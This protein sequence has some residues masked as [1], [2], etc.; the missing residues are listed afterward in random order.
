[1]R[2]NAFPI[3]LDMALSNWILNRAFAI[4]NGVETT[5]QRNCVIWIAVRM[6]IVSARRAVVM[7]AGA[8]SSVIQSYVIQDVTSMDNV[9]MELACA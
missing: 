7:R 9:R 1:M 2:Y 3:V 6:A 4:P 8:A 5:A